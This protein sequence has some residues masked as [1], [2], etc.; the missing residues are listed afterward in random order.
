MSSFAVI[1]KK[2]PKVD[3]T[4]KATGDATF[5]TDIYLPVFDPVEAMGPEAPITHKDLK[6]FITLF[7][8]LI[9]P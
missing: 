3:A 4:A 1:G 2:T 9:R 8:A 5:A 6:D 7:N